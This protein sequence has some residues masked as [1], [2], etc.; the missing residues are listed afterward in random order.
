MY[1]VCG[2]KN[3]MLTVSTQREVSEERSMSLSISYF[4]VYEL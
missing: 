1:V 3:F 2:R 4:V